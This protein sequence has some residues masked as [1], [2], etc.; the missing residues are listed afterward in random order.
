[1]HPSSELYI[2]VS[3][4]H[5]SLTMQIALFSLLRGIKSLE[6]PKKPKKQNDRTHVPISK[7]SKNQKKQKKQNDRT[8][9]PI[10]KTSKKQKKP[11]RQNL[12]PSIWHGV[13]IF[14]FFLGFSRENQ[15]NKKNKKAEPMSQYLAW[16]QY[17]WFFLKVFRGKTKK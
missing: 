13:N 3:D 12:C 2:P 11:K 8:H 15:K 4:V 5:P 7:T 17:F 9:I 14:G 16:G 1:M 6:N 10:S